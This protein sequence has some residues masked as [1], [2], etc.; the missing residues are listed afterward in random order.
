[1]TLVT[2]Q[3]LEGLERGRVFADLPTPVTIGREDDNAVRLNDERV[4][5]FHVKIQSDGDQLILT[6][7]DSTNGTR[8]NGHPVQMHVL[9]P[10]DQLNIG[11]CLLLFGA[12][13]EILPGQVGDVIENH[14][15][16]AATSSG[17]LGNLEDS[18]DDFPDLFPNGPPSLP[19]GFGTLQRAQLADLLAYVH[20]QIGHTLRAGI[21]NKEDALVTSVDDIAWQRLLALE[22]KLAVDLSSITDPDR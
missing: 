11:R 4:S 19:E 18:E 14:N 1:M 8:V 16:V 22:M 7:L 5:R 9:R 13:E 12:A 2:V 21:S 6:D 17:V 3:V 20:E 15:T 10:G